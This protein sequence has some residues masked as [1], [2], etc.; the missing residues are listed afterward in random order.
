MSSY[1]VIFFYQIQQI[2]LTMAEQEQQHAH[3]DEEWDWENSK[4]SKVKQAFKEEF[5]ARIAL[6]KGHRLM[7][8][9]CAEGE[10]LD[11]LSSQVH[12]VVGR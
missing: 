2:V 12:S 7:D 6:D 8:I 11:Q 10:F 3:A 1:I 4:L 5:I 9:G